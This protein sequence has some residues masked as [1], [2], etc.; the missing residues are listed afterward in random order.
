MLDKA[1]KVEMHMWADGPGVVG[2]RLE[3]KEHEVEAQGPVAPAQQ[4]GDPALWLKPAN[5]AETS[6]E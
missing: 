3:R 5:R 4:W 1:W 2:R 6:S